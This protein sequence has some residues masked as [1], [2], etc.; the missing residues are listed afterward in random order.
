MG[1][2]AL[3]AVLT[4]GVGAAAIAI[5][6]AP[7]PLRTPLLVYNVL[8]VVTSAVGAT[9][10]GDPTVRA[11]WM[12]SQPTM[13]ASWLTA[14]DKTT[15]WCLVWAPLLLVNLSARIFYR[16][17]QLAGRAVSRWTDLGVQPISIAAVA[18]VMFTYCLLNLALHGYLGF[19]LLDV[20]SDANYRLNIQLR[21]EM[22]GMLGA[23][24][25]GLVYMALPAA[26]VVALLV[27]IRRRTISAWLLTAVLSAM[28]VLLDGITR[29]KSHLLVF[30]LALVLASSFA[31]LLRW[32]GVL[33]AGVIGIALL[34]IQES[35]LGGGIGIDWLGAL[36][37]VI[38]RM[39]SGIP[40]YVDIFPSQIP[41]VGIDLGQS[42]IGFAPGLAPNIE[43]ANLMNPTETWVQSS[44]PAPAHVA[45]YA[46][47]GVAWSFVVMAAVGVFLAFVGQVLASARSEIGVALG[48]GG[49]ISGYYMTQTDFAGAFLHAYGFK[50]WVLTIVLLIIVQRVL[51]RAQGGLVV[52]P[53]H[54]PGKAG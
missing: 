14:W 7:T 18:V 39:A 16:R 47:A 5:R 12:L 40:F 49:C 17:F 30:A 1:Y 52:K 43:V 37:N 53:L 46:Q 20:T 27:A 6:G 34:A 3:F 32:R 48:I 4:A 23:W 26:C 31:G 21:T 13:D 8:Y 28:I 24:Q 25:F 41:F 45:A 44:V 2:W 9:A 51:V 50:W 22:A 36:A 10:L 38:F 35:L 11:L 29:T 42:A 54:F 33:L 15:Y 19:G